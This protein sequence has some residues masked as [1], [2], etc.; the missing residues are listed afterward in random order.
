MAIC[1]VAVTLASAIREARELTLAQNLVVNEIQSMSLYRDNNR[2]DIW[3]KVARKLLGLLE[4]DE[5]TIGR[6]LNDLIEFSTENLYGAID[7]GATVA[8]YQSLA[9]KFNAL[10]IAT[11][12]DVDLSKW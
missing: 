4:R 8:E 12:T 7:E 10:G 9:R 3:D 1:D 11:P 5:S 6:I 2:L